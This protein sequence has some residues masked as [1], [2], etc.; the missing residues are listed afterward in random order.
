MLVRFHGN[1]ASLVTPRATSD[2]DGPMSD[3][4]PNLYA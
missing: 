2:P 1:V 4:E 3:N